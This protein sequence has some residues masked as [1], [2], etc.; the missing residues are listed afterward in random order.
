[1]KT[2]S[3][4]KESKNLTEFSKRT[5][6]QSHLYNSWCKKCKSNQN[7]ERLN[8]RYHN[9]PGFKERVFQYQRENPEI[10]KAARRRDYQ[11][12]RQTY[13]DNATKWAKKNP[14]LIS[15]IKR[16]YKA[17]RKVWEMNG[18][19]T[20]DEWNVLCDF[21]SNRCLSC[22]RDDVTLTVDHVVPLSK[23]G[24][25]MIDNIQPLCGPC[26]SSKH[27]RTIDYRSKR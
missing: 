18:S 4:C 8:D 22:G 6:K 25:N 23:G 24:S 16:R 27:V 19:F 17:K 15:Q 13:I 14:A 12:N 10:I 11:K 3:K 1:M 7:A 2:C 9:E 20:Q 5:G 26:N 21:Y